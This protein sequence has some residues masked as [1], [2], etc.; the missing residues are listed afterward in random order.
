M[1][2]KATFLLRPM[3]PRFSPVRRGFFPR[4]N[5]YVC[6]A[7]GKNKSGRSKQFW[8]IQHSNSRAHAKVGE[9]TRTRDLVHRRNIHYHYTTGRFVIVD[10]IKFT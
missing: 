9:Q 10:R 1:K 3:R 4:T 8:H 5:H 2:K 6:L 7:L